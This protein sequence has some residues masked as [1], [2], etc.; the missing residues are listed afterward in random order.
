MKD[1]AFGDHIPSLV[2]NC[3]RRK[4]SDLFK[5]HISF[6]LMVSHITNDRIGRIMAAIKMDHDIKGNAPEPSNRIRPIE[7]SIVSDQT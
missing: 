3:N 1:Q 2:S 7:K 4:V 6:L 5:Y